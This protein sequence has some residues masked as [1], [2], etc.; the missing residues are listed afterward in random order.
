MKK[1]HDGTEVSD[2]TPT[3]LK[4]KKRY[5]LNEDQIAERQ[6]NKANLI[7]SKPLRDWKIQMATT[8]KDMSQEMFWHII[9]K[10]G[11]TTGHAESQAKFDAKKAIHDVKPPD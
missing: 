4:N 7:T 5:L 1:L 9:D 3:R 6:A 10:H 8:D 2:D 11:G